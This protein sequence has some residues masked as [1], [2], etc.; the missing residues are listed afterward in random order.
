MNNHPMM[1]VSITVSEAA[2]DASEVAKRLAS[3]VPMSAFDAERQARILDRL[4]EE[5]TE[6]A[7]DVR[8]SR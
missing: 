8:R 6:A 4:A 2:T 7:A 3:C 1:N 5:L